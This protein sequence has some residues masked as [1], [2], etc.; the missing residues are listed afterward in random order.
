[1]PLLDPSVVDAVTTHPA[2]AFP[3]R[4]GTLPLVGQILQVPRDPTY[5]TEDGMRPPIDEE[6]PQVQTKETV[7]SAWMRVS[8]RRSRLDWIGIGTW[9]RRR[10]VSWARRSTTLFRS[11]TTWRR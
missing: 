6:D 11:M 4:R 9:A 8:G 2:S 1:M 5:E 3:T 10:V 7:R